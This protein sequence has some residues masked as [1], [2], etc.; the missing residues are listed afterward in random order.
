ME[1][2]K[3]CE[4]GNGYNKIGY[5]LGKWKWVITVGSTWKDST[6]EQQVVGKIQT[7]NP[8]FLN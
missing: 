3:M 7:S 5:N 4:S 2:G 6:V 1:S 8:F